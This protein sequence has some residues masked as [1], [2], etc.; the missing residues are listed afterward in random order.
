MYELPY[1]KKT[2]KAYSEKE[3]KLSQTPCNKKKINI[4]KV[5]KWLFERIFIF[6]LSDLDGEYI[7]PNLCVHILYIH[8]C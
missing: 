3:M 8:I 7:L 6:D 1:E 4:Q 5:V 2:I